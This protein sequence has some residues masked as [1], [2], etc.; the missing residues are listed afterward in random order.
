M[1][2][3]Q[4]KKKNNEEKKKKYSAVATRI[5]TAVAPEVVIY[6]SSDG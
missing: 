6:L 3:W 2:S 4:K 1:V 5:W